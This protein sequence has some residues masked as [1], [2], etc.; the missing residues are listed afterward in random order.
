MILL[1]LIF[2][3]FSAINLAGLLELHLYSTLQYT[4]IL[5]TG[6]LKEDMQ[7]FSVYALFNFNIYITEILKMSNIDLHLFPG[8]FIVHFFSHLLNDI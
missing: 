8:M 3:W 5:F 4:E 2:L 6:Y 7:T 1:L